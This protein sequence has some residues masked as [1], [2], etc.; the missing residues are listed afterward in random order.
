MMRRFLN[1]SGVL[2]CLL[3]FA[4]SASRGV[5][6]DTSV[7]Q[8]REVRGVSML[9]LIRPG[10]IVGVIFGYYD[11]HDVQRSDL[12]AYRYSGD[13]VPLLKKVHAVPGDSWNLITASDGTV[14]IVVNGKE[15]TN[16][17]GQPYALSAGKARRLRLYLQHYPK[18]P[19]D[20]Y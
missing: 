8:S 10:E 13:S 9:P 12:V 5:A 11:R 6:A 15:L 20:R 2:L 18:L 1:I 3:L 4:G 16:S 19:A 17:V 14:R 7:P